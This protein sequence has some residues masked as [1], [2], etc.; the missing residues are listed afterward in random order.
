MANDFKYA[1]YKKVLNLLGGG[2]T[3]YP[4]PSEENLKIVYWKFEENGE[5]YFL[6][7]TYFEN[8]FV[9]MESRLLDPSNSLAKF[10]IENYSAVKESFQSLT[11]LKE[12]EKIIGPGLKVKDY[13]TETS[14]VVYGW[15]HDEGFTIAFTI[16]I[17]VYII[18]KSYFCK[19]SMFLL[20]K[21]V[22]RKIL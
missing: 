21:R 10:N 2:I 11:S 9:N 19:N 15:S 14:N 16:F 1:S 18:S 8:N 20:I 6:D 22:I 12:L 4:N 3:Y 13:Y 7:T 5:R 17:I